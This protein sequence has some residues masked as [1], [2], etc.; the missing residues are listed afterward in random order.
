[1]SYQTRFATFEDYKAVL[2]DLN[3]PVL[4]LFYRE[5]KNSPL[6]R[7]HCFNETDLTNKK[8]LEE[9]VIFVESV[10]KGLLAQ[11]QGVVTE[12]NLRLEV[13]DH[14][15]QDDS[16]LGLWQDFEIACDTQDHLSHY[17]FFPHEYY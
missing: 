9:L 16:D 6:W 7:E 11:L 15:C 2:S 3:R 8:L 4:N 14:F 10:S 13:T 1:M 12:R 5:I 17:N